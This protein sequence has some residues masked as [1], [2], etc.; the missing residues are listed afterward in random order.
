MIATYDIAEA[1][2]P[3][4]GTLEDQFRF[5][6]RYAILAPSTRNTQPW[7][8][9]L[10]PNGIEIYADYT[11]RLPVADR[12]NREL[13]MSIGAAIMNLRVAAAHYGFECLVGYNHSGDSERP[14]AFASLVPDAGT[15]AAGH[16][17]ASLFGVIPRRH[18]NRN[19][20]LVTRIP[21]SV[22]GLFTTIGKGRSVA[23]SVST[24]GQL[25]EAV[26]ELVGSAEQLLLA[27][28]GYR[29]DNA[30]WIRPGWTDRAD[31]VPG[32]ALGL[33]GVA[34]ALAPWATRVLDLG[35]RQAARDK[36]LCVEA[37]G[38]IVLSCDD[39]VPQFL[40][41]GELLEEILL[42]LTREGL[43]TSYFNMLIQAPEARLKL[44]ALLGLTTWPQLLLRIGYCL[45]EPAVTPRRSVDEV[46]IPTP[47]A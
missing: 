47:L 25:N 21:A 5:L 15:D 36:N 19:P 38:L 8:F 22:I 13:L 2:F 27:D 30:E 29:R 18:T 35:R 28:A 45:T 44:R 14:I 31:G 32:S 37:P 1:E 20:F 17:L 3:R 43:Q 9:A 16:G 42:T 39:T 12:S 33:G 6:L 10:S 46:L 40:E 34:A 24:D 26:G 23:V 7:R 11:R 41:T 4:T